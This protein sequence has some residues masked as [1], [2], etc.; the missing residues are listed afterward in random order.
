MKN[1][2]NNYDFLVVG[3]GLIG[4]LAALSLIKKNFK[5]LVIDKKIS[6][7][8]DN[9]TL[10]VNDN[11]RKFLNELK[12]WD[13]II[14]RPEPINKIIISDYINSENLIFSMKNESMGSVIYNQELLQI[15]H[16]EL[17]KKK[18]IYKNIN[19]DL[20][21]LSIKKDSYQTKIF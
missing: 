2:I 1:K 17:I 4:S 10:A 7:H 13:K 21:D 20:D 3:A 19:I 12:L 16:R 8:I 18:C 9:R 5:V 11:S 15:S 14:S 6:N